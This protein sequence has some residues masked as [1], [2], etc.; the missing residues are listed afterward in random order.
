MTKLMIIRHY[1]TLI[2]NCILETY[3]DKVTDHYKLLFDF[4]TITNGVKHEPYLCWIYNNDIQQEFIGI[5]TCAV[6]MLN[7]MPTDNEINF[8]NCSEF[9]L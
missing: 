5:N 2:H 7:A 3:E 4:A 6:D 8:I 1:N 9:R